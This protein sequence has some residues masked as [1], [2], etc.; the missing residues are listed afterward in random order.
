MEIADVPSDDDIFVSWRIPTRS[1]VTELDAN[2][3]VYAVERD[4]YMEN[5]QRAREERSSSSGHSSLP[6]RRKSKNAFAEYVR[7]KGSNHVVRDFQK[8]RSKPTVA[9]PNLGAQT[10]SYYCDDSSEDESTVWPHEMLDKFIVAYIRDADEELW[11]G[12]VAQAASNIESA[13]HYS[14]IKERYYGAVF[15]RRI[16]L[17]KWLVEVQQRLTLSST[18]LYQ[19]LP[20]SLNRTSTEVN[21]VQHKHVVDRTTR[22][23]QRIA[24]V[25]EAVSRIS[26]ESEFIAPPPQPPPPPAG[27]AA[28][29]RARGSSLGNSL[30]TPIKPMP[31]TQPIKPA[32]DSSST[33]RQNNNHMHETES[34]GFDPAFENIDGLIKR[35]KLI[36]QK[37]HGQPESSIHFHEDNSGKESQMRPRFSVSNEAPIKILSPRFFHS[38]RTTIVNWLDLGL[39]SRI[40]QSTLKLVRP[41]IRDGYQRLEWTCSCGH[42]MYGDYTGSALDEFARR[43]SLIWRPRKPELPSSQTASPYRTQPV[44]GQ[45]PEKDQKKSTHDTIHVEDAA[46]HGTS[47]TPSEVSPYSN[48]N[49]DF[50]LTPSTSSSSSSLPTS[51]ATPVQTQLELCIHRNKDHIRIGEIPIVNAQGDFLVKSDFELFGT[52]IHFSLAY[53]CY[54]RTSG[55]ASPPY[56]S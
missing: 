42:A 16:Y 27:Y 33:G 46:L 8:A 20:P 52:F 37:A 24:V 54:A 12:N 26:D 44:E 7:T 25:S 6:L 49:D 53:M 17:T 34:S 32:A 2:S 5:L 9:A 3:S 4:Q 21:S 1:D 30:V 56:W 31:E 51:L 13:I 40:M 29:S 39:H 23:P 45:D 11:E 35:S 41:K 36:T 28:P 18:E 47:S 43:L 22:A 38:M 48:S 50:Q 19:A 10:H 55:R 15:K 14:E